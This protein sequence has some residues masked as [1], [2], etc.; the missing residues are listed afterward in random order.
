[1]GEH[2]PESGVRLKWWLPSKQGEI[3]GAQRVDVGA[4]IKRIASALLWAHEAWRTDRA[5]QLSDVG[6]MISGELD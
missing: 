1:M 4:F 2:H 3:G 6:V 5:P